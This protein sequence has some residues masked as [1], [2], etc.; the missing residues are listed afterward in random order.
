[1]T[2][3]GKHE[4]LQRRIC[5][6]GRKYAAAYK[7]LEEARETL[8]YYANPLPFLHFPREIR[9]QIYTY[10]LRAPLTVRT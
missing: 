8:G 2:S 6:L 1:M 9:D 4:R 7:K 10:A 3:W 5:A